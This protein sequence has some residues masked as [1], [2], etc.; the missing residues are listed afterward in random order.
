[1]LD[2]GPRDPLFPRVAKAAGRRGRVLDVG[3]GPGRFVLPLAPRVAS[4]TAVDPSEA[5]LRIVRREA[6]RRGLTNVT[7]VHSPWPQ[8]EVEP[9]EVSLCSYVLPL[10]E[11]AAPFLRRMDAVTTER[12]F[13]SFNA[14]SFDLV[15]DTF[16]RHF[17][18][19][20]RRPG[21]TYLDLVAVLRELGAD[22][23]VEVGRGPRTWRFRDLGAAVRTYREQL[24]LADTPAVRREL[25]GL[26]A[27]WLVAD[28]DG[29][30]PPTGGLP[31]AVVSWV[32]TGVGR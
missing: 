15:F 9:V 28:G 13:V 30:V 1:M 11:E 26:L 4:V 14:A 10:I 24:L 5:M 27:D 31:T 6:R 17:H 20:P 7:T 32:P 12:A 22:P 25:K 16:W 23:S 2:T 19:S 21:P 29:L 18:G 8:A 3:S